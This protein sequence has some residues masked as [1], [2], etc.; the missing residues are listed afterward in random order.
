M[1][2]RK[3]SFI[4]RTNIFKTCIYI[5]KMIHRSG[6]CFTFLF[7]PHI[8]IILI[9]I[10]SAL[11][12]SM[13]LPQNILETE[14]SPILVEIGRNSAKKRNSFS[15]I[16]SFLY[17]LFS[18]IP[19]LRICNQHHR[20]NILDEGSHEEILFPYSSSCLYHMYL[21]NKRQHS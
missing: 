14:A 4:M 9:K 12:Q 5:K 1:T 19:T 10:S 20:Q 16:T 15:D 13:Y 21:L 8:K 17:F 6:S 11:K 2:L 7:F 3:S 18:E